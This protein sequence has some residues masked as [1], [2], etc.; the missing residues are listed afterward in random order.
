MEISS[1]NV[2]RLITD[3]IITQEYFQSTY[4]Y[5]YYY[6]MEVYKHASD[7]NDFYRVH[8]Y[9]AKVEDLCRAIYKNACP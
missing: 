4:D 3:G 6:G 9:Y 5:Y 1:R 8:K 2:R 7:V